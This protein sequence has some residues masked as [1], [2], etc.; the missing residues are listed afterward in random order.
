MVETTKGAG[1]GARLCCSADSHT[2]VRRIYHIKR[3]LQSGTHRRI[4][5]AT[6]NLQLYKESGIFELC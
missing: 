5:V 2:K 6:D 1:S 4:I 3:H